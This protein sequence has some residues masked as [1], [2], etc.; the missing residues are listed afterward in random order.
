M[1]SSFISLVLLMLTLFTSA[2]KEGSS[3]GTVQCLPNDATVSWAT[4]SNFKVNFED[5]HSN[6]K[7]LK[8][9]QR[10]LVETLLDQV[11]KGDLNAFSYLE[12][13]QK[14]DKTEIGEIFNK[15]DTL[16]VLDP[17]L[18]DYVE[19]IVATELNRQAVRQVR[20][21]EEWY[22]DETNKKM[23]SKVI[24]LAPLVT[25]FNSDGSERGDSPL[26]WVFFDEVPID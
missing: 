20:V 11:Q 8:P 4:R 13:Y 23:H 1:R 14:L 7:V 19:K 22:Y 10:R 24:G 2:C 16:S 15:L 17:E 5:Q 9:G 25:V 26:F 6:I 18:G 12:P 3:N 21:K